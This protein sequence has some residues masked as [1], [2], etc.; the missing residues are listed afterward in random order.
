MLGHKKRN[1]RL[2]YLLA[3]AAGATGMIPGQDCADGADLAAPAKIVMPESNPFLMP[4]SRHG[5]KIPVQLA[6]QVV[7]LSDIDE[8]GERFRVVAYLLASWKDPR[9]GFPP[10]AAGESFR[11]YK[12]EEVWTPDFD[13]ANGIIPHSSFD[14]T[15]RV[16]ADGTVRYYER[17]S[18]KLSSS[19]RLRDFPFDQQ[20]LDIFIHPPISEGRLVNF[21]AT[22]DSA[23]I[24]V[25][26]RIYSSLA[27]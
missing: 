1:F 15:L 26:Q 2:I 21:V 14:V 27:Q 12:P 25:E 7:N 6:L 13:F 17:S 10:D 11:V 18:A 3:L 22:A 8:V 4:P 24:S 20:Q 23:S 16:F 5:E 9:L 19:F